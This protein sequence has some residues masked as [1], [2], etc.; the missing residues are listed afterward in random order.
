MVAP[1]RTEKSLKK[2]KDEDGTQVRLVRR[3]DREGDAGE[4]HGGGGTAREVTA[5]RGGLV[6]SFKWA[7][8]SV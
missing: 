5:H 4:P 1:K 8:T 2:H 7:E 6:W 3:R